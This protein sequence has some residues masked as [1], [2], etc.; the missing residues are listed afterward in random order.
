MPEGEIKELADK[1]SAAESARTKA[2]S[3]RDLAVGYIQR[4]KPLLDVLE[5]SGV[6]SPEDMQ[7]LLDAKAKG[8]SEVDAKEFR[9]ILKEHKE[10]TKKEIQEM[11][12]QRIA[13]LTEAQQLEEAYKRVERNISADKHPDIS[14]FVKHDKENIHHIAELLMD[15]ENSIGKETDI[16]QFL[17]MKEQEIHKLAT[18]FKPAT[19]GEKK[20]ESKPTETKPDDKGDDLTLDPA[21]TEQPGG[22]NDK[23]PDNWDDMTDQEKDDWAD[24]QVSKNIK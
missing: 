14:T 6:K 17:A 7:K 20:P 13:P 15:F 12:D 18:P 9:E 10:E 4:R 2:E 5:K 19:P 11:M 23:M 8:G 21:K 24:K 1:L 22:A 16:G 3:D